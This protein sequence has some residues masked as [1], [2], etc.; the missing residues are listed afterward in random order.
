MSIKEYTLTGV[1][2]K[3]HHGSEKHRTIHSHQPH[4]VIGPLKHDKS[5]LKCAVNVKYTLD[6]KELATKKRMQIITL[7]IYID[8]MLK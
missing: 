6:S 7:T 1:K 8:Y 2:W 4:V 5:K 3:E